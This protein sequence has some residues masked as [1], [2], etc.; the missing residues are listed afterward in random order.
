[1]V[2]QADDYIQAYGMSDFYSLSTGSWSGTSALDTGIFFENDL[3]AV[4]QDTT[5]VEFTRDFNFVGLF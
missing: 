4:V 3:I 1:M 2:R 5:N